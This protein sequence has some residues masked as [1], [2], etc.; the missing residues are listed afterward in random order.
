METTYPESFTSL[1]FPARLLD[2]SS[3]HLVIILSLSNSAVVFKSK[4]NVQ[5]RKLAQLRVRA[6]F[7]GLGEHFM[8]LSPARKDVD[9]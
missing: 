4:K 1:T 3:S 5:S 2:L 6:P 7:L 9:A 8:G